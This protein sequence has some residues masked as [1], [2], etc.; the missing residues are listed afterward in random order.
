[1][2]SAGSSAVGAV[3]RAVLPD[4]P[5]IAAV[6]VATWQDAYAGL[7]PDNFLAGLVAEEWAQRWRERLSAPVPG[8]F[9]LVFE[10]GGRVRGFASGGPD[11][12][13]HTGGEV[14]AIYVDPGCQGLGAGRR[15]MSAAVRLLAEAGFA[16]ARLWVLA[17]NQPARGFYEAQGWR[18]DGVEKE[19]TYDRDTGRSLPEVRYVRSLD[20]A[21]VGERAGG[22]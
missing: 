10:S 8:I 21:G 7:L 1:V 9:T 5:A 16:E 13:G 22:A 14:F 11:R 15:L 4:A 6:H 17:G 3:R 18:P 12:H 20:P 19:W 2:S